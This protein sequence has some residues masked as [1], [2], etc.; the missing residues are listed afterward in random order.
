V[1]L[2]FLTPTAAL[3]ALAALVH[4]VY[5]ARSERRDRKAS[6]T[7]LREQLD[8]ERRRHEEQVQLERER[9][10]DERRADLVARQGTIHGG[11]PEDDHEIKLVNGGRSVAREIRLRV[12]NQDGGQQTREYLVHDLAPDA[13]A[14]LRMMI[15]VEVG[16]AQSPMFLQARWS[17]GGGAHDERLIE[18]KRLPR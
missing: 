14:T 18:L 10:L 4:S 16:R 5:T 12:V 7:L 13:D 11:S 2:A 6:L 17:D 1:D 8:D 3:V 15:P 9:R